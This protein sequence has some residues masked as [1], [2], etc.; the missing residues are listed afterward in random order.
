M[1][2]NAIPH[3][4]SDGIYAEPPN[5]CLKCG[6]DGFKPIA[7]KAK[8]ATRYMCRK[9]GRS[10]MV[11][12]SIVTENDARV[13]GF[14][15]DSTVLDI[16]A[17]DSVLRLYV[18]RGQIVT[19]STVINR[20]NKNIR[21]IKMF[22]D[23]ALCCLKYG[24]EWGIDE[25]QID[26]RGRTKEPNPRYMEEFKKVWRNRRKEDPKGYKKAF[27]SAREKTIRSEH[28]CVK[29][30]LTGI[31][32]I[33]TRVIIAHIITAKRPDGQEMY[34]LLRMAANVAGVPK[35]IVT[36]K[37]RAYDVAVRK[38]EKTLNVADKGDIRHIRVKARYSKL[39]FKMPAHNN[40][41]ESVWS[42]LKR[43][44]RGINTMEPDTARNMI[45]Y[46]V[47]RHNFIRP[48]SELP[49]T[50]VNRHNTP[51]VINKTPVMMAGHPVWYASFEE[52]VIDAYGYDKSFIFKLGPDLL[53]CLTVGIR[54]GNTVVISVK[55][56]IKKEDV[57]EI[58]RTLQTKCGFVLDY[59]KK[60]WSKQIDSIRYMQYVR[61]RNISGNVPVQTFEICNRCALV[62]LTSQEVSEFIGYRRSGGKWIT[63]PNCHKCRSVL[64]ANPKRR[65]GR[66]KKKMRKRTDNIFGS[67]SEIIDF[68]D[69]K[70]ARK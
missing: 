15:A 30:Y 36:D 33:K 61:S 2:R 69:M 52:I 54:K 29:Q 55:P 8:A 65:T 37:Y 31:I 70:N 38:L 14:L 7:V 49:E 32:D 23:D 3:L 43:N 64:S 57:I 27:E 68:A 10:Y 18:E 19:H 48:H 58:D 20:L 16:S 4:H 35:S 60:E 63:Q 41:I 45:H 34:R 46:H 6:C 26:I 67:Q 47:I 66:N 12:D 17:R 62:A 59:S 11:R 24:N 1:P 40:F 50:R 21:H 56:R 5:T 53:K 28:E 44:M 25:T 13:I 39:H 9:C 22:T 51:H 42:K